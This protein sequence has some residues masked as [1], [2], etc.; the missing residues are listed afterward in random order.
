M[1][2]LRWLSLIGILA[3]R[4]RSKQLTPLSADVFVSIPGRDL[5][6][7]SSIEMEKSPSV[8]AYHVTVVIKL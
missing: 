3:M 1:E 7:V 6:P 2:C 5:V 8:K 4:R